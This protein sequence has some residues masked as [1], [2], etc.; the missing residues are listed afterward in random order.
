[1][2]K[3]NP[4]YV[5]VFTNYV[6]AC[7]YFQLLSIHLDGIRSGK[8]YLDL[9]I[10]PKHMQPFGII[11]GGVCASLIEAAVFWAVH[12]QI[13]DDISLTTVELKLNYLAAVSTGSLRVN[14]D[15]LKIGKTLCLGQAHVT[16]AKGR[17]VAHGT[18]TMML[19]HNKPWDLPDLPQKF[20]D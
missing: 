11:H 3:L 19:L 12:S 15:S 14:G 16:D 9:E 2:R 7:P 4:A 6:N 13:P 5:D 17:D 8:S 20:I 10:H 18:A 1:M